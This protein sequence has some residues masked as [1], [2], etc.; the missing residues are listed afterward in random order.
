MAAKVEQVEEDCDRVV[1]E[2]LIKLET[3][4]VE[5]TSV[6]SGSILVTLTCHSLEGLD[7]LWT[8]AQQG[9]LDFIT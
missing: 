4:L 8:M 2:Q 6:T 3:I 7:D 5:L 9:Q 1:C